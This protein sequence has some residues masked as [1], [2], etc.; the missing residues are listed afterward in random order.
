VTKM[1]SCN[2]SKKCKQYFY[3]CHY[4]I[5]STCLYHSNNV[6][7]YSTFLHYMSISILSTNRASEQ[8]NYDHISKPKLIKNLSAKIRVHCYDYINFCTYYSLSAKI[9]EVSRLVLS[10]SSIGNKD[11]YLRNLYNK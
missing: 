6:G 9:I 11:K 3:P 2:I 7:C 10:Q 8:S 1:E 5:Y 4:N